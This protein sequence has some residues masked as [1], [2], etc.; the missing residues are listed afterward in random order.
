MSYRATEWKTPGF[1]GP[2]TATLDWCEANYQFSHYIA[3]VANS[4]SNLFTIV[5]ATWGGFCAIRQS[6]PTRYVTGYVGV[7]LVGLGSFAFHAT[8]LFEA[9]L[10][11]ELPMIYVGSMALWYL[12]DDKPG[13][14]I[15]TARTKW[16]ILLSIMFDILFTWSY[17]LYRNPVY[18]QIVF[19]SLV[20]T[21][22]A[23]VTYVLRWSERIKDIPENIRSTIGQ[24][25]STGAAIFALGFLVWNLDNIFCD[26][27]TRWKVHIGWP[28]AFLLEGHS[29]WHIMTGAGTY[30]IHWKGLPRVRRVDKR[31][32]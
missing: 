15:K 23:R 1:Y 9:Q 11:D 19:A 16:L 13:Y 21:T 4:F 32:G 5:L 2:V 12:F 3:E 26:T 25:F 31:H 30:Y 6:L 18:H 29:W 27:L 8:L 17:M 20:L 14:G 10:A 28:C 24:L 22:T 7:A